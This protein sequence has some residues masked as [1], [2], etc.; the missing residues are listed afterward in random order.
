MGT[1]FHQLEGS[2]F[3][4]KNDFSSAHFQIMLDNAAQEISVINTTLCLFKLLR[5]PQGRKNASGMFQRTT[6]NTLK[7]LVG[8]FCFQDDV[9]VT[10]ERKV[11]V[12]SVGGQFRIAWS[13][14]GSP[15]MKSRLDINFRV[16]CRSNNFS[17]KAGFH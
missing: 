9:L 4:V 12:R 14:S 1:F 16:S 6:E 10:E 13:T 15:L 7:G 11:N 2:K 17:I 8:I 5:L 3:Y